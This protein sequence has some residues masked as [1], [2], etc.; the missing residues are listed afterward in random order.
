[1]EILV[2]H[3][4]RMQHGYICVAGVDLA[5]DQHVRPLPHERLGLRHWAGQGGHFGLGRVIDLGPTTPC[6]GPPEVEDYRFEYRRATRRRQVTPAEF[7]ALLTRL[8]QPR[9]TTLFGPALT[10]RG[11]HLRGVDAGQGQASLGC[12][13]PAGRPELY[14]K[15][16]PG[17]TEQVRLRFA[18]DQAEV[19]ASVT[20]IRLYAGREELAPNQ[21]AIAWVGERLQRGDACLLSVGLT[22]AY[23]ADPDRPPVHWLQ[24]NNIHFA[25]GWDW[26]HQGQPRWPFGAWRR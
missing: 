4:T 13:T 14:L 5:T 24:V 18:D 16:R 10:R 17:R 6:G 19:D 20:D 3:A 2:N 11:A 22:R 1:M 7:W 12:L 23:T 9:L 8:A 26:P 21:P 25:D 15:A